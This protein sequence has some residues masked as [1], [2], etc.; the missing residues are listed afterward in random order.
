MKQKKGLVLRE[1]CGEKVIIG[2]GLGAVDFG[3]MIVLNETAV[4]IWEKATELGN[5]TAE[6]MAEALCKEYAVDQ[7]TAIHD[8]NELFKV[9]Q[10]KGLIE[11]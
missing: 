9:W 1:V 11:N 2:E 5:F 10:E 3:N 4:W 7:E 6:Q 8:I